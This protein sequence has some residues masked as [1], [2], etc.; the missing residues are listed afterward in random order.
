MTQEK[1]KELLQLHEEI[2][3]LRGNIIDLERAKKYA[4]EM[5][6]P[7][8]NGNSISITHLDEGIYI[9]IIE[10]EI[11]KCQND[12]DKLTKKFEAL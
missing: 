4:P 1:F 8:A 6:I 10:T 7:K 2:D 9:R 11:I 12:I 5:Y 3:E